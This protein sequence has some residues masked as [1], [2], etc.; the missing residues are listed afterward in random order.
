MPHLVAAPDKFRGTAEAAD[1]AA[2][3]AHAAES[4]GWTADCAPM[5]DGGEGLLDAIGG[6]PRSTVVPGPLGA[7]TTA[8]W[9]MVEA[10][11]GSGPQAVIEMS[12]ASGRALLPH[13]KGDDP[14]RADTAG[15]GQLILAARDAGVRRIVIGCG[16]SATTDGGWGAFA[17]V[18]ATAPHAPPTQPL[19]DIELVVA[20]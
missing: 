9:R 2:A 6:E 4:V 10:A 18:V 7:P 16:G 13:P 19:E 11:D 1:V 3:M 14:L 17:A 8:E 20:C 15:V 12:R 5:S